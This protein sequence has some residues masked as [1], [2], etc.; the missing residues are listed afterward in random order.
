MSGWNWDWRERNS[1]RRDERSISKGV[2]EV[3]DGGP[4][5]RVLGKIV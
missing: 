4:E 3:E 2:D 1:R 5:G